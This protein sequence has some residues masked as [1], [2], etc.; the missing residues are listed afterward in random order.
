M[1]KR[2]EELIL[3]SPNVL[4]LMLRIAMPALVSN[5]IMSLYYIIDAKFVALIGDKALAAISITYPINVFIFSISIGIGIATSTVLSNLIGTDKKD[6]ASLLA[7]NLI[8]LS[9]LISLIFTVVGLLFS[10]YAIT[11]ISSGDKIID[12][13]AR[14][15]I[16]ITLLGSTSIFLP[17]IAN[18]ILK[19]EGNSFDPMLTLFLGTILN[20][21]LDPILM[22]GTINL[23][24]SGAALATVIARGVSGIVTIA[25]LFRKNNA[26]VP[27]FK[28]KISSYIKR[29]LKLSISPML[30]TMLTAFSTYFVNSVVKTYSIRAL[31]F[32]GLMIT[33]ADAF[34]L[35][36]TYGLAQGIIPVASY[37]FAANKIK[38]LIKTI[39]YAIFIGASISILGSS[40]FILLS[41]EILERFLSDKST[42]SQ[43]VQA[44]KIL[45]LSYLFTGP[46]ITAASIFQS[47][48]KTFQLG[49]VV[50][51]R[52]FVLLFP[53]VIV[54]GRYFNL[55]G[56]WYSFLMIEVVMFIIVM[57][58]ILVITSNL[59]K[60]SKK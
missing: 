17:S 31:S 19:G 23:G 51:L 57:S 48:D 46:T 2:R 32:V 50:V 6:E 53:T 54:M 59:R 1:D 9:I 24:I 27:N 37:N 35:L 10:E 60:R 7:G 56:I 11:L 43:G 47:I 55:K 45:G 18:D 58:W 44:F 49:L 33:I 40:L 25:L 38:R 22:F 4:K 15:Y 34:I 52:S 28:L 21:F 39:Y 36:P 16:Y 20:I 26:I 8:F 29:T 3:N 41:R 42:I 14:K 30:A 5:V 13:Y 12:E